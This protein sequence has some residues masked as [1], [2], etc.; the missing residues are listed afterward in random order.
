MGLQNQNGGRI[1]LDPENRWKLAENLLSFDKHVERSAR[2]WDP[3][4]AIFEQQI[5]SSPK[6]AEV[7]ET[8]MV[9]ILL[10]A[11]GLLPGLFAVFSMAH[12]IVGMLADD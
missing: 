9:G 8:S 5:C 12:V 1:L 6:V 4:D 2:W 10:I 3:N 7:F 11:E